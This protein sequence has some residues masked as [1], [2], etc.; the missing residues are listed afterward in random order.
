[1]PLRVEMPAS[2]SIVLDNA[3]FDERSTRESIDSP[4]N[5]EYERSSRGINSLSMIFF[6]SSLSTIGV[7]LLSLHLF[8]SNCDGVCAK[9]P[10]VVKN[11]EDLVMV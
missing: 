2:V 4:C 1:M 11:L 7:S 3:C 9:L 5:K 10:L 8:T 6:C